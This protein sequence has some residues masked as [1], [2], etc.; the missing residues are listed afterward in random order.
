MEMYDIFLPVLFLETAN[1]AGYTRHPD[2]DCPE[3]DIAPILYMDALKCKVNCDKTARCV[4]FIVVEVIK[5][6]IRR[7]TCYRKRRCI[8]LVRMK[9]V[10]LYIPG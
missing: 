5:N 9:K 3:N 4:A 1:I 7:K 8:S 6:A 2:M 10:N